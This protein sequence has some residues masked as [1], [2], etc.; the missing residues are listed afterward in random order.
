LWE[1]GVASPLYFGSC[2]SPWENKVCLAAWLR[3]AGSYLSSLFS[4]D[5]SQLWVGLTL[6]ALCLL[7]VSLLN[8]GALIS[9]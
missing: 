6:A 3:D 8:R 5:Q 4:F 9:V 1:S 2:G 7:E